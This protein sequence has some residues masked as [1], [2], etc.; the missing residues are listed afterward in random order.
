MTLPPLFYSLPVSHSTHSLSPTL[1]T[2]CLPLPVYP[3]ACHS[4][5]LLSP[6][7][8]YYCHSTSLSSLYLLF[9]FPLSLS[10]YLPLSLSTQSLPLFLTCH[11]SFL[12][13]LYL[14][15]YLPLSLS[16]LLLPLS[17]SS[18]TAA[19]PT[20]YSLPT[21]YTSVFPSQN[22]IPIWCSQRSPGAV[23]LTPASL[24]PAS[25]IPASLIPASLIPATLIPATL[26]AYT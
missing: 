24:T 2:H 18:H 12:P 3:S 9:Y 16:L 25:L 1:P 22:I 6:R 11:S 19:T 5:S 8:F 14:S 10:F 20:S 23:C 21:L 26:T 4:P 7:L 15:F 13:C 17:L